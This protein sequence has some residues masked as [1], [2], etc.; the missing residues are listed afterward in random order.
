MSSKQSVLTFALLT[1]FLG[2]T[3]AAWL[4]GARAGSAAGNTNEE[5]TNPPMKN[6]G[7]DKKEPSP[8][9]MRLAKL[10]QETRLSPALFAA[11]RDAIQKTAAMVTDPEA[12]ALTSK[13]D[14]QVL[15]LTWEDT[16]RYKGSS[17]GPN[18]SDMTIQVGA[19]DPKTEKF[20]VTCMPV[21]R[22][23]NF[24]DK[25]CDLDPRDFTLLVGNQAGRGLKRISL[26]DFLQ[27]PTAYLSRP[28]SWKAR[29]K[30]LLT[31]R[32][33]KVL[34]SAQACFLPVP[35]QGKATFN[36][37]VFNYQSVAGDPAVLTLLV[38]REGSSATIIDNKRDAFETGAVWGQR[39]FHNANGQ[40]ASLTGE[41]ES[42][43]LSKNKGSGSTPSVGSSEKPEAGLNMVLLVQI[44]LKQKRPMRFESEVT[45]AAIPM[46]AAPPAAS[47]A[48]SDVENAVIGHGDLEGSFTEIDNL[49]IERDDRFPVRVTVQFYKATSNGVVSAEDVREIKEQLDRVYAHSDYV[50]SL[51]TE[52]ETGRVTEYEGVKVQP[53][54]WWEQFWKR[55]EQNTGDSR[56]EAIAKLRKL[57]GYYYEEQP[58][59]DL[60]LRSLL[61]PRVM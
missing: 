49:E 54:D 42:E 15:N 35:K 4:A 38:T 36:P 31:A 22:Y 57:L 40:R 28:Q 18:S 34:V 47:R 24:S 50:G 29:K 21:I 2:A 51:V 19:R 11:Y 45:D 20:N 10:S 58:V 61:K 3:G 5:I 44:P 1:G 39:L 13:H 23:P 14:L 27:N 56:E 8:E 60:Y 59:S 26:H 16:G 55:H 41:R 30:T 12:R 17:V 53:R 32:D 9:A 48:R 33:S 43:F 52:G 6:N 25:T 7:S 46:A 37:V